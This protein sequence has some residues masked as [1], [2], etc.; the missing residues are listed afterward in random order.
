MATV[1]ASTAHISKYAHI[2]EGTVVL[3]QSSINA[4]AEIGKGCIINTF[5]NIEH[6]AVVDDYCHIST[7]VMVNGGCKVGKATFLGSQSVVVNGISIVPDCIIAA[8]SMIRKD[9]L[10]KGVYSGNPVLLRT[11]L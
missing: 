7:G 8:G 9:I 10:Q 5:A 1:I 3:H 6:D 11:K 4:N 2:G